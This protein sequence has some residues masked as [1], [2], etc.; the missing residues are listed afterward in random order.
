MKRIPLFIFTLLTFSLQAQDKLTSQLYDTYKEF[1]ESS[2][3]ERRIKHADIQP[4]IQKFKA[5]P[6]FEVQK[7]GESIQGRDLHLISIG[8]GESNIFL[9]SQMHGDEPTATMAIFDILNFLDAPDFKQEKEAIL[10][11]LK[12]HFLPMLNPDGAEVFTRRN[13]LGIDINRDA[14][15]LQSPEGQTLKRLRDSLDADFGFNLHDQSTYYNAERTE[16][17][18]RDPRRAGHTVAHNRN[19]A[20]CLADIDALNLAAGEFA[21]KRLCNHFT[22]FVRECGWHRNTN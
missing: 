21:G 16:K 8:E 22:G 7:V 6:K 5:N 10:S 19:N 2:L 15:R 17:P 18:R 12:L 1:K 4:L 9:W 3:G 13:F 14:L 11:K 20:L